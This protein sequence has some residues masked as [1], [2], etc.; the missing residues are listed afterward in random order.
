MAGA[1]TY[2]ELRSMF[3]YAENLPQAPSSPLRLSEL[4]ELPDASPIKVEEIIL[5]D[6]ALTA[7]ILKTA[8]AAAFGRSR[9]VT[10]VREAVMVL[11]FRSIRSISVALWT[12]A[13]VAQSKHATK[14][15]TKRFAQSGVLIGTIASLLHKRMP[16]R[17]NAWTVEEVFAA[18]ILYNVPTGLLSI[19][20]PQTFDLIYTSAQRRAVPFKEAFHEAY[21]GRLSTLG[22]EAARTMGLP[23]I[24]CEA[25]GGWRQPEVQEDS[26]AVFKLLDIAES[27]VD[28]RGLGVCP[29]KTELE[30]GEPLQ[31]V[32]D[33]FGDEFRA[34]VDEAVSSSSVFRGI[35]A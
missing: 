28:H 21:Q 29:W 5:A 26:L 15:D 7:G 2:D 27:I 31:E 16:E 19:L 10:T 33:L 12:N 34:Y 20:A 22:I 11:G 1:T 8:S 35:A 14:L 24:F 32:V 4:L 25:I 18:G 3:S 17:S 9:P 6:P 30:F 13:L 23:S